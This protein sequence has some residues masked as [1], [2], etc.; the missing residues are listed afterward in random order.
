M[1]VQDI[2]EENPELEPLSVKAV[3][4]QYSVK[5]REDIK[6][7]NKGCDSGDPLGFSD[8]EALIAKNAIVSILQSTDDD[9][10]KF[11]AAK[12][13]IDEKKGRLDAAKDLRGLNILT[14]LVEFNNKI[15][16]IAAAR[17]STNRLRSPVID[18]EE[19]VKT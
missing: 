15:R 18:I 10:L 7:Q 3:L 2:C 5:Y 17:D 8:D 11:R 12:R 1:G 14:N 13:I 16:A 6:E 9:Y 4:M 19:A